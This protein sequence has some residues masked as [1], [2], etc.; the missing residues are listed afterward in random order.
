MAASLSL[1]D[2]DAFVMDIIDKG[3]SLKLADEIPRGR[4]TLSSSGSTL[5]LK[6]LP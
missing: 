3:A 2:R 1:I 4:V 5:T 6:D